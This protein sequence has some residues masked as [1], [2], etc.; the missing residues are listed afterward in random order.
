[1]AV[2]IEDTASTGGEA[3]APVAAAVM[4]AALEVSP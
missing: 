2:V 3:S 4:E 1:V